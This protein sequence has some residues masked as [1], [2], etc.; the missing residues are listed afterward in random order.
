VN[1]AWN[2]LV[3]WITHHHEHCPCDE[4][5]CRDGISICI[6]WQDGS[7][8]DGDILQRKQTANVGYKFRPAWASCFPLRAYGKGNGHERIRSEYMTCR[9]RS[10]NVCCVASVKFCEIVSFWAVKNSDGII[11]F[12][13]LILS[14]YLLKISDQQTSQRELLNTMQIYLQ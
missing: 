14:E 9:S 4:L 6:R 8:C 5:D 11:K 1:S 13:Y 2:L 12:Q 3:F 7:E 10:P